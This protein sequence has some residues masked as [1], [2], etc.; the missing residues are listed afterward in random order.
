MPPDHEPPAD[1]VNVRLAGYLCEHREGIILEW[2]DRVLAD[3][4]IATD[5]MTTGMLKDHVPSLFD[6]LADTLREYGNEAV[7]GRA[8][9]DADSHG[10]TR[11]K[12]GYSLSE[13]LRE[14]KHL[15]TVLIHHLLA[16]EDQHP[17][18]GLAPRLYAVATVHAFIDDMAIRGAE[19]FGELSSDD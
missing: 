3:P 17:D 11:W 16:F 2:L 5:S 7:A 6:D 14:I 19:E 10:S 9:R 1:T 13:L 8:A 12:E 15:R 4:K 18:F